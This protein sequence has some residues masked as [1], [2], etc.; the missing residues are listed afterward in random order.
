[1]R[2]ARGLSANAQQM[3]NTGVTADESLITCPAR[4]EMDHMGEEPKLLATVCGWG[5]GGG[6]GVG[7]CVCGCVCA[8][9]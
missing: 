9:V 1:M 7:G 5:G 3:S 8:W 4:M 6:G 2:S